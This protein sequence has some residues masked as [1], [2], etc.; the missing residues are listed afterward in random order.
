MGHRVDGGVMDSVLGLITALE[1][2]TRLTLPRAGID[3]LLRHLSNG[4]CWLVVHPERH[5]EY[6]LYPV[7]RNLPP[8]SIDANTGRCIL[9]AIGY[10]LTPDEFARIAPQ[11]AKTRQTAED[12]G[13]K[14]PRDG[15]CEVEKANAGDAKRSTGTRMANRR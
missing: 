3:D 6:F 9:Q 4:P 11:D 1:W 10:T 7:D 13:G 12:A 2:K 8:I 14:E 5:S 15:D